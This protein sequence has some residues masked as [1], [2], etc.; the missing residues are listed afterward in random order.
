MPSLARIEAAERAELI[1]VSNY[2]LSFD[3]PEK[4][5]VFRSDSTVTF[6]AAEPGASTFIDIRAV[7]VDALELNGVALNPASVR[8]GRLPLTGLQRENT[9][10]ARAQMRY[11]SDGE[12]LHR[13][14]DPADGRTYLYAMSF[15][16]AAPRWFA[17]FDQPDLKAVYDIEVRCPPEWTVLGNSPATRV[18]E[19]HWRLATSKPM[20]TYFVTLVAGPYASVLAEHD[21]IPLGLHARQSL[22]GQLATE[23]ADMLAI[24]RAC[25]DRYHAMFGIRYPFGEY[26]QVFVADFNAGAMENP[27]CVTLRDL[28]VYRGKATIGE[29]I[30]RASTIAHEMAHMWFGDLVTMRWWDD[31]WLNESFAE[32][33]AYRTCAD[34]PGYPGNLA[35][36]HF[37][38]RRKDWGSI[39]DQAP[40]THPVAGNGSQTAAAALADFDGISYAKGASALRQLAAHLGDEIFLDGLRRHFERHSYGNA[41]LA[42]LLA[43]WTAAGA[44]ELAEWSRQWLQTAGMDTIDGSM[45]TAGEVLL[46]R[47]AADSTR[48]HSSNPH[49]TNPHSTSRPHT[50]RVAAYDRSGALLLDRP[51]RL[52]GDRLSVP[53]RPGAALVV[54]D[55]QDETWARIRFGGNWDQV[56]QVLPR[57]ADGLTRVVVI[58]AVRD[59]VR[60]SDLAPAAALELVLGAAAA[61]PEELLVAE[62]LQFATRELAGSYAEPSER[63]AR[64]RAVSAT[65][66]RLL[67]QAAPGTDRQ[68]AVARAYL[69][70]CDDI[71]VLQSW[72]ARRF[73]EGLVIDPELRWAL[74]TRLAALGALTAEEIGAELAADSSAAGVV[75]AARARAVRPDP[76]AKQQA[77]RALTEPSELSAYELYAIADGFFE[78]SQTQL[79]APYLP[80]FFP[81]MAA[82]AE[83]R[84]GFA[85]ARVIVE[86]FPVMSASDELLQHADAA[87]DGCLRLPDSVRRAFV[88]GVDVTRRAVRSRQHFGGRSSAPTVADR[89]DQ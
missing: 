18:A 30:A 5:G 50:V 66:G 84:D 48:Q 9:L 71:E 2:E 23:A 86:A 61:E 69:R 85:L 35:W 68:L 70:A 3:L 6:T 87:L 16:D 74:L 4:S 67:G 32:Y 33:L 76:V 63:P 72:R 64:R 49:S 40:S 77:W 45:T 75:H 88:D 39:A 62:L 51:S 17:C 37:G 42:D 7:S 15:L 24:T 52:T 55:S 31:L 36:I 11:S 20:S 59:A 81:E 65:A 22:A 60:N 28:Y 44:S 83:F 58:N 79:T 43:A 8:D 73:P 89:V 34:L 80:R 25:F 47:S 10:R 19:G 56:A 21:G 46:E 27:G 12:G 78:Q 1:T 14:V 26:H 29:R 53:G 41:S 54:A 57:L 38:A 13:H 82:T